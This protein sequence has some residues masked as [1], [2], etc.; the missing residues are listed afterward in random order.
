ML[1]IFLGVVDHLWQ[2]I[3][4]FK[5]A[6]VKKLKVLFQKDKCLNC[7][8]EAKLLQHV[9]PINSAN[10][11]PSFGSTLESK[12]KARLHVA[13]GYAW[14]EPL[15][16]IYTA[17]HTLA[18]RFCA[19][20][21]WLSTSWV[22]VK[23]SRPTSFATVSITPVKG[24]TPMAAHKLRSWR[25]KRN[26]R[27]L[28]CYMCVFTNHVIP[29][30]GQVDFFSRVIGGKRFAIAWAQN[31]SVIWLLKLG[32]YLLSCL[33]QPWIGLYASRLLSHHIM[34]PTN[35]KKREICHRDRGTTLDLNVRCL[36]WDDGLDEANGDVRHGFH[37]WLQ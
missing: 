2:M 4:S 11:V 15:L 9:F 26:K 21:C 20:V 34:F 19:E 5:K 17:R 35:D 37:K 12:K 13:V 36:D 33:C 16:G 3:W 25:A 32:R 1:G 28:Q 18:Y 24:R 27:V 23:T 10:N 7:S 22:A 31:E 8:A 14:A 6:W 30:L 29:K